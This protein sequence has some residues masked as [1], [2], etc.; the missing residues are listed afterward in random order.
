MLGIVAGIGRTLQ[1]ERCNIGFPAKTWFLGKTAGTEHSAALNCDFKKCRCWEELLEKCFGNS[2][3]QYELQMSC[4]WTTENLVSFCNLDSVLHLLLPPVRF[5]CQSGTFE[6]PSDLHVVWAPNLS[7]VCTDKPQTSHKAGLSSSVPNWESWVWE[8]NWR[9]LTP[10]VSFP[11]VK[12]LERA[13]WSFAFGSEFSPSWGSAHLQFEVPLGILDLEGE[14]GC[15]QSSWA[16]PSSWSAQVS[17]LW[18]AGSPW[19][20]VEFYGSQ[21]WKGAQVTNQHKPPRAQCPLLRSQGRISPA[22]LTWNRERVIFFFF[23]KSCRKVWYN[24]R[25][26]GLSGFSIYWPRMLL[27][28]WE[29]LCRSLKTPFFALVCFAATN[30]WSSGIQNKIFPRFEIICVVRSWPPGE[31]K[32]SAST[33]GGVPFF[34]VMNIYQSAHLNRLLVVNITWNQLLESLTVITEGNSH[35]KFFQSKL[36]KITNLE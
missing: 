24:K 11:R 35:S 9:A 26:L 23:F 20:P 13:S 32:F 6:S 12:R 8:K 17:L 31:Q 30:I 21:G 27:A 18:P 36:L 4:I 28:V 14:W 10:L 1:Q 19:P 2:S 34:S 16:H 25:E 22:R 7:A 15:C 5:L 3:A 33:E 29:K